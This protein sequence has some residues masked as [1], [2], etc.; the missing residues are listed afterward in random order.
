MLRA[1]RQYVSE[2]RSQK[3]SRFEQ[4]QVARLVGRLER[5]VEKVHVS[6]KYF[7]CITGLFGAMLGSA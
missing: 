3:R 5:C 4:D 1:D 7:R 6:A 2:K